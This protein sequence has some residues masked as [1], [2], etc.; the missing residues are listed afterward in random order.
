MVLLWGQKRL[1]EEKDAAKFLGY[2]SKNLDELDAIYR[3]KEYQKISNIFKPPIPEDLAWLPTLRAKVFEVLDEIDFQEILIP[4]G[5]GWHVDHLM[6]HQIFE[7]WFGRKNLMFYEDLP[8][9]LI[10]HIVRYRL[11]EMAEYQFETIDKS[12]TPINEFFAWRRASRAYNQTAM[13]KNLKPWFVK[14]GAVPV[15]SLYL[16]RLLAFHRRQAKISHKISLQAQIKLIDQQFEK[17]VEAMALYRTQFQEFFFS[18]E[19]CAESLQDYAAQ[20]QCGVNKVERF[21]RSSK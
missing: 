1:Q 6:A 5:V 15:V 3:H 8:Y 10:P 4:L 2:E 14:L 20:M 11:N 18:K 13:M 17:K 7:P 16:N 12:L 19:S 9:G 21:W